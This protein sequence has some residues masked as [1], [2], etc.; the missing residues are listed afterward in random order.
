MGR[1][2]TDFERAI[3]HGPKQLKPLQ[4]ELQHPVA[5][6]IMFDPDTNRRFVVSIDVEH[7]KIQHLIEQYKLNKSM[8]LKRVAEA[9]ALAKK[10]DQQSLSVPQNEADQKNSHEPSGDIQG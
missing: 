3:K 1:Q 2:K 5:H 6:M 7:P 10:D 8:N 4:V 9:Q